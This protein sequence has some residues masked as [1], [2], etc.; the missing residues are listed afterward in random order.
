MPYEASAG[1][2]VVRERDGAFEL[3]VIR[4]RG[5][6]VWALPKG[7]VDPGERP[8]DAAAR[9]VREETGLEASLEA[10]LGDIRYVYQFRGKRIFKTVSFF[11]FRYRAGEI[12]QLAP[13][14]RVEVDQAR[15]IP[16]QG[17]H[18]VLAYRGEKEIVRK[19]QVRLLGAPPAD[20]AI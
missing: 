18:R 6:V 3:A 11:L 2:A 7:H 20:E 9:E 8:E 10:S 1:G 16:L 15:W 17:A 13:E 14:M 19:V 5:K 12:D 4:P